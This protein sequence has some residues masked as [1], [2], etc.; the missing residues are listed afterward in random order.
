MG[1][2]IPLLQS[3][4]QI[5]FYIIFRASNHPIVYSLEKPE[6]IHLLGGEYSCQSPPPSVAALKEPRPWSGEEQS[7]QSPPSV[8]ALV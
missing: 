8:T 1:F 3:L 2:F 7:R 6:P 4:F 5:I